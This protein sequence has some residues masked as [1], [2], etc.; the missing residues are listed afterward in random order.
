[1][2][3]Q[4]APGERDASV[5][6]SATDCPARIFLADNARIV[7]FISAMAKDSMEIRSEWSVADG[8]G[9][10]GAPSTQTLAPV[11]AS[12]NAPAPPPSRKL[13]SVRLHWARV[14]L[15]LAAIAGC[16]LGSLYWWRDTHPQLQSGRWW[17]ASRWRHRPVG[18]RSR[19][20]ALS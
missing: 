4:P 12:L 18:C 19:N 20:G 17:T 8:P 14:A 5:R 10:V 16:S 11:P 2:R 9:K 15:A 1:M 13:I 7:S 6:R 3:R